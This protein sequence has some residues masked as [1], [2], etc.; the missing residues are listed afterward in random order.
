MFVTKRSMR[1]RQLFNTYILFFKNVHRILRNGHYVLFKMFNGYHK[2][3]VYVF[4]KK[5]K[6]YNTYR[7]APLIYDQSSVAVLVSGT[8][9]RKGG[10]EFDRILAGS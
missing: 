2:C 9:S 5:S 1:I 3:S 8:R 4:L 7:I 10:C 6:D